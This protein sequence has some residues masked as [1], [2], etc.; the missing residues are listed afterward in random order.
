MAMKKE[1]LVHR[2]E[3]KLRIPA[4][5]ELVLE[6]GKYVEKEIEPAKEIDAVVPIGTRFG[7]YEVGLTYEVEGA[8]LIE[9]LKKR[10]FVDATQAEEKSGRAKTADEKSVPEEKIEAATKSTKGE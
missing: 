3:T 10:G 7:D 2:G 6:N 8:D 1:K 5:K 4:R 9:H